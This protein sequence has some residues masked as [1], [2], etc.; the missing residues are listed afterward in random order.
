MP[1]LS[2]NTRHFA[3]AGALVII[4]TLVL[5]WLLQS[6]LP[7]PPAASAQAAVVDQLFS[8]HVLLIAFLF[9]LVVVFMLYALVVF[10]RRPGDDSDG[11]HFEGNTR[12]EIFWT[13]APMI[14]VV[15][16]TYLG[17]VTLADVTRPQPDE[18]VVGVNGF[19]WGWS[20]EYE[21]DVVSPELVLPV[22]QPV[23]LEMNSQD[24]LHSFWVPEFRVKQ[25]LVPGQVQ[26][27]RFTPIE[28]G[29]YRLRCAELCGLSHY[30]MLAT[31]RVVPQD[32]FALWLDTQIAAQNPALVQQP[33]ETEMTE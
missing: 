7:M 23:L 19:Q 25:D 11:E 14:F 31:V 27:L 12:L 17:I 22:D 1:N 32:E 30:N 15:I 18:L 13:A 5:N 16:F 2:T 9:A 10:R 26:E 33:Q 6:A 28:E 20:F 21:G 24:V 8:W 3:T 29:E 4:S